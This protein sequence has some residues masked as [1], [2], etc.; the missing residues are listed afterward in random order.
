MVDVDTIGELETMI[1]GTNVLIST[2]LDT[3]AEL[4]ALTGGGNL[5]LATELDSAAEFDTALAVTGTPSI[6]T[7]LRG[8]W[9]WGTVTATPAGVDTNVQ[10]NDGGVLGADSTFTYNKTTDT[11]VVLTLNTTTLNAYEL[12]GHG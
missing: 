8:D 11:L 5:L 6:G 10:F 12:P 7:F 9:T 1:G 3:I 2:E 4:E